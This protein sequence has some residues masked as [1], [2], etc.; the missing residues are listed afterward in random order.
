M[1]DELV[2]DGHAIESRDVTAPDAGP[3]VRDVDVILAN[4][5]VVHLATDDQLGCTIVES[6]PQWVS[7]DDIAQE[8]RTRSRSTGS[9][10]GESFFCDEPDMVDR[11]R[12]TIDTALGRHPGSATV[13]HFHERGKHRFGW[14]SRITLSTTPPAQV[15]LWYDGY[16]DNVMLLGDAPYREWQLWHHHDGWDEPLLQRCLD[17]VGGLVEELISAPTPELMAA[18]TKR[19][20]QRGST[21]WYRRLRP[22]RHLL[23]SL[24]HDDDG[25][26][27]GVCNHDF[28][29][30]PHDTAQAAYRAILNPHEH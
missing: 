6:A 1:L 18:A 27:R 30:R 21:N 9:G 17:E 8:L 11:L 5:D 25:T 4:H 26:V 10:R 16:D 13:R 15:D 20:N 3:G 12:R 24:Q 29:S 7:A 23:T 14:G 19:W 22:R 2:A 28:T